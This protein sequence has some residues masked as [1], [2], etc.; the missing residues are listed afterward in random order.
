MN[1]TKLTFQT[2]LKWD[3]E[4]C[5]D[6][7]A[8]MRWPSGIRCPKCGSMDRPYTIT[9]KK[10]S[11]NKVS[12]F[13]KCRD[14]KRQFTAT[15]GTIFED[16]HIPLNKWLAALFLMVSSKKGISAHQ[17]YRLLDLGSYRSA[18]FMSHRIRE[19]M[20]EKGLLEP[21]SGDVEAD[22]TYLHPR[23]RR[24]S[25]ARHERIKDEIEMGIRPRPRRKGP[26]E[27]KAVVFGM[28]ER[29]GK[30]RTVHVPDSTTRTLH[31]IIQHWVDSLNT[32]L[33]TDQHPAYRLAK[34]LVRRHDTI[35]H[36]TEY[37]QGDVH[38]QNID[39]YWSIFKR[40]IYG[41]FHHIGED[42]LPSYLSEFDFRRNRRKVSDVSRF[43]ALMQQLQGRLLWY[44]KTPQP[45]NPHA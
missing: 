32:R 5:R 12:S 20:R 10:P 14:C 6:F 35:N 42:Y 19:A 34:S 21:L 24:G 40:G 37:V 9:R 8:S 7:L 45:Q 30:V 43:V 31:P 39:N 15:V 22:E 3:E 4:Q 25:P 16:S 17:L 38:T 33:I 41:V 29:N 27:G 28:Q 44:C 2:V 23:R 18:W 26:Y 36:E 11:K 1:T 13:F